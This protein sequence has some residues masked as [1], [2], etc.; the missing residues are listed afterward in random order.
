MTDPIRLYEINGEVSKLQCRAVSIAVSNNA[1]VI[2]ATTG[3]IIRVM[4][5]VIQGDGGV[6]KV[7]FKDGSGGATIFGPIV[8]SSSTTP[9][10]LAIG[11]VNS[12]YFETSSGVGLFADVATTAA[13]FNVF[14]ISYP[15]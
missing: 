5:F 15:V 8:V 6:A 9:G 14:Y 12:G 2:A 1:T 4:G 11:I 13:N 7:T 3:R 10:Q